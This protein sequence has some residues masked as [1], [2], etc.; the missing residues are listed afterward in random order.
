MVNGVLLRPLDYPKPD[1][2]VFVTSQFPT[3][4]FDQFWVSMPEFVEYR[5]NTQSFSS[6]GACSVSAVNLGT[7]PPSR[8]VRAQVTPS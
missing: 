8:P 6:V 1:Q 3:L 5:D 2:L 7:D 4:G